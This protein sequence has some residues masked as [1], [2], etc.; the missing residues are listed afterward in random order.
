MA[1][2]RL[3]LGAALLTFAAARPLSAQRILDWQNQWY[4]GVKGGLLNYSLPSG[5]RA[6]GQVGAEWLITA[7]RVALYIGY[8]SSFTAERDTFRVPG[9]TTTLDTVNFDAFRRIQIAAVAI[10][11]DKALQPYVGLG[12]VIHSLSN[13][14]SLAATSNAAQDNAVKTASSGGF[15]QLMGGL[16]L[17]LGGKGALFAHYQFSPQGRDFLI[18]GGANSFEAGLRYAFLPAKE[19]DPTR[20]H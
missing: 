15:L 17:R 14:R 6:V 1:R 5:N 20:R 10:I 3:M 8:S 16:Q 19:N 13:A 9:R 7:R 11:G 12:F 18:A 2:H 4:W